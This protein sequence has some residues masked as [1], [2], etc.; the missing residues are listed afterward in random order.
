MATPLVSKYK[1]VMNVLTVDGRWGPW[2]D[3]SQCSVTCGDGTSTRRRECNWPA[4]QRGGAPC[5]GDATESKPCTM[6]PC[7]GNYRLYTCQMRPTTTS[8]SVTPLAP[9]WT[10][11]CEDIGPVCTS[12]PQVPR[13]WVWGRDSAPSQNFNQY[14]NGAISC[15]FT[16]F[17][18]FRCL[19]LKLTKYETTLLEATGNLIVA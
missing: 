12:V 3:W 19:E 10:K 11:M 6:T 8:H 14:H 2:E 16:R 15:I 9:E 18:T 13:G 5:S 17:S 7:P 4:A 1:C